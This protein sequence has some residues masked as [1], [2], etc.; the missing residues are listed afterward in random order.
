MFRYRSAQHW[1]EIFRTYYGPVLKAFAAL[2]TAGQAGLE[3]DILTLLE[4]Y[5]EGGSDTLIVPSEYLEV[6]ATRR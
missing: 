2:D 4:R 1:L 6:V 5:N 3:R